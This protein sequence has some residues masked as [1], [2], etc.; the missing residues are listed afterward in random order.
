MAE[1][2]IMTCNMNGL[3]DNGKRRQVFEYHVERNVICTSF[4]KLIRIR[5]LL[6]CGETSGGLT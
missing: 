4:K 1:F 6:N 3:R 2:K 5:K